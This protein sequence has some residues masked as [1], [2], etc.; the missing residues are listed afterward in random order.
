MTDTDP[1]KT[2]DELLDGRTVAMLMTMIGEEHSSRPLTVAGVE[3]GRLSFLVD[4]TTQWATAIADGGAVTHLTVADARANT[5]LALNGSASIVADRE[6]VERL[7]SP[8]VGAFF[9]GNDDPDAAVLRFDVHDGEYWDG[10]SG[11]IGSTLAV[12]KAALTDDPGDAG[13]HGA[14]A[15]D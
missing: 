14:V 13:D 9:E 1:T 12:V 6:E 3:G 4:R 10:P 15:P 7:W 5:Y 11:R 8:A 2:L